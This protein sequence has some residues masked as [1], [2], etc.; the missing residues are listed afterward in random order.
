[1]RHD[2][3]RSELC[4]EFCS[5]KDFSGR[6][7]LVSTAGKSTGIYGSY[8]AMSGVLLFSLDVTENLQIIGGSVSVSD[9]AVP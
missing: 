3:F 8:A 4:C 9:A 5:Y 2:E 6:A 7:I 1:M